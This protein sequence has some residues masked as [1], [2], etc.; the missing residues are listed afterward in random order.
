MQRTGGCAC[1]A[2]RYKVTGDPLRIAV[3]HCR[4][5]Q[6][7]TGSAFGIGCVFSRDA[8]NIVQGETKTFERTANSGNWIRL[9]FCPEC[10]TTVTWDMQ[11]LPTAK[12]IAG[13]SFDDPSWIDPK[14]HV[15]TKSAHAWMTFPDDVE[16]LQESNFGQ[17][18]A[19]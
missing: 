15:W 9:Q 4:D 5:C 19:N 11:A 13:G 6:R 16:V 12:G 14:L 10:G 1:G 7:R 17:A 2:V 18:A 8:V 3:C